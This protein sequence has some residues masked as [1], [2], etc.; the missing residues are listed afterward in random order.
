MIMLP[1]IGHWNLAES[2]GLDFGFISLSAGISAAVCVSNFHFSVL[3]FS[4]EAHPRHIA[5]M[6]A[7]CSPTSLSVHSSKFR[8]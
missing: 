3:L 2:L 6:Y 5:P 8:I 7:L 1:W 4:G